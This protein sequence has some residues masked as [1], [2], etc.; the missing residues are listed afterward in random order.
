[1]SG[2]GEAAVDLDRMRR[3]RRARL[4]AAMAEAGVGWLLLLGARA[5][6]YA[7]G[8]VAP[9]DDP[10]RAHRLGGAALVPREGPAHLAAWDPEAAA[11]AIPPDRVH[12]PLPAD[13]EAG[14]RALAGWV[15]ERCGGGRLDGLAVDE[16]TVALL[17]R[18]AGA[19]D[20]GPVIAAARRCKTADEVACIR[21]AQVIDEAALA[22]VRPL[23]RPGAD[24]RRL[25]ARLL[26][27]AFER[28][29]TANLVEPAWHPAGS[30]DPF[31]AVGAGRRLGEGEVVWTDS[32]VT[33]HGLSADVGTTWSIGAPDAGLD[34]DRRVWRAVIDAALTALQPGARGIAVV[35][36]ARAA[37]GGGRPWLE[38]LYLAHGLGQQ[39]A[40][41][42]LLGTA[43][44][45]AADAAAVVEVGMVL[46]L[47]P[48]V[49]RW[50]EEV[51][52]EITPAGPVR[53]GG[54]GD[55]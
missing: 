22:A 43:G 5:I 50:R 28:G 19:A 25:S 45:E 29:A 52:V 36:A 27:E 33:V 48:V 17:P 15:A 4:S 31:P 44:G 20:A 51:V 41:P 26:G 1:M 38:H 34:D 2:A 23:A 13:T 46:V 6:E 24:V 37:A 10:G 32:G 11:P 9:A 18:L 53:I 35:E 21:R 55:D 49:G 39:S 7:T 8:A 42:P 16:P 14:A 47:E 3:D 54:G 40:E 12:P 30:P